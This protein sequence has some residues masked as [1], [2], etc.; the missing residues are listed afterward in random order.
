VELRRRQL[1][2]LGHDA[3]RVAG[4]G[5]RRGGGGVAVRDEL[6]QHRVARALL[7]ERQERLLRV[8]VLVPTEVLDA[9][10]MECG[11]DRG[12]G[13]LLGVAPRAGLGSRGVPQE[14]CGDVEILCVLDE[15]GEA[16]QE[17]EQGGLGAD[18]GA[19]RDFRRVAALAAALAELGEDVARQRG[20]DVVVEGDRRRVRVGEVRERL[21]ADR[22][23]LGD[24]LVHE[25]L[26]AGLG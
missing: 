1:E 22:V 12:D 7:V 4:R 11:V 9:G 21:D 23:L 26:R 8:A 25:D 18:R 17:T 19:G 2:R 6:H 5:A 16:R 20:L 24:A 13:A 14:R 10:A 3:D 15:H